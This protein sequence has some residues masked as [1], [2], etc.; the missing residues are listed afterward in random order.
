M[1]TRPLVFAATTIAVILVIG[2]FNVAGA[3]S[4]STA[5]PQAEGGP[6]RK[7]ARETFDLLLLRLPVAFVVPLD[8][9]LAEF[10][11][12]PKHRSTE[13]E[14]WSGSNATGEVQFQLEKP[15]NICFLLYRPRA[16]KPIAQSVLSALLS[17]ATSLRMTGGD[18]FTLEL[19][20]D[21]PTLGSTTVPR[22]QSQ[23]AVQISVGGSLLGQ[24]VTMRCE[25]LSK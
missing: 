15:K 17:R 13:L 5:Q 6:F 23:T 2:C 4:F 12:S 20:A 9:M 24:N 14:V 11:L 10:Q 16:E 25:P 18:W 21:P 3:K 19:P 8:N 7:D 22:C 1:T